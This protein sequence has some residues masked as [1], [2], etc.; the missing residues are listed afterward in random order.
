MVNSYT[1]K[2]GTL[3]KY[4]FVMIPVWIDWRKLS[5]GKVIKK[6]FAVIGLKKLDTDT[7]IIHPVTDF[8]LHNW[9]A[10]KFNTQ[11]KHAFNIVKFL[12]YLM[13]NKHS[14]RI[15]SMSD[16]KLAD[17]NKYLNTLTSEGHSIG[18]VKD[19]ERTLTYFYLWLVDKGVIASIDKNSFVKKETIHG[20]IYYESPF[21]VI[22]PERRPPNVEHSF[23]VKYIPLLLEI[24]ILE[25][26]PIAL[27]VYIQL[28][29]GLRVGEVV[30]LKRTQVKK[31]IANGDFLFEIKDQNF[32]S[33]LKDSAGSSYVKRPRNQRIF[34]IKDWG[35]SLFNNHIELFKATDNTNALFVN[36]DGKAMSGRSYRQYFDKLKKCFIE[37]LKTYGDSEDKILAHHLSIM[38]WSTHIGRGTFTNMLAEVAENPYDIAFPR[39]DKSL[40]SSL[41]YM[42]RTERL[43]KKLEQKFNNM[44]EV[45]IP[46]LIEKR[47]QKEQ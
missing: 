8:I 2:I 26:M 3:Q 44:H 34:Q 37:F 6:Q 14:M 25:A 38:S 39:G 32:R 43:R 15:H 18:T 16:L 29:G 11:K 19:S 41:S 33:D 10:R 47:Q 4:K 1:S 40:L 17:G 5:D 7:H 36:R 28:F 31:R 21:Q 23:P 12:N 42:A 45:Y 46:K 20:S 35:E 24:A 13:F 22:Y 30:N 9:Q 27:G